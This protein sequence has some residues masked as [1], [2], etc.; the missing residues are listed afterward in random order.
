MSQFKR[1]LD[2]PNLLKNKSFF[3]FG[4]RATGKT[5]LIAAQLGSA[6]IYDLLD[7]DVYNQLLRR[8]KVIEEALLTDNPEKIIVIDEVQKLPMVLDEVHRI[9]SKYNVRFLL[10]GSSARK[11]RHGGANLLAGRAWQAELFALCS[12]EIPNFDLTTYLN[13]GGLPAIYATPLAHEELRSYVGTY[14]KEEV[15]SEALTRNLPAFAA[16]LDAIALSNG[17]EINL[18]SLASDC[19]VSPMTL[20]NYLSILDDTLIGFALPGFTKTKKRKAISR[21][22]YYLF[23]IGLV[24][25]IAGRGVIRPKSELF[26][27][28][29]EHFVLLEIRAWNSYRRHYKPI[30]YWRSTSQFEV[31]FIIGNELAIEVKATDL[32]QDRHLKGLRALREEGL[33]KEYCVVSCDQEK[34]VTEDGITI[35]PWREFLSRLWA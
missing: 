2:L 5:S 32:V 17:Q 13:T 22:K 12:Q 25:H 9:I 27:R 28:A 24:N 35:Y 11:L 3:L 7:A 18:E 15:Q 21:A 8:P 6:K 20:K 30:S 23:D 26:G 34:R 31:D 19:G 33:V 29:F 4:P 1:V 10:T 16:F 14:L